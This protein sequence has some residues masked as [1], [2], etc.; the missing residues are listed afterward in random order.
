ME[1]VSAISAQM[2][3]G[4]M[5][6]GVGGSQSVQYLHKQ[7]GQGGGGV[8]GARWGGEPISATSAQT[9]GAGGGEG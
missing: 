3:W 5:G 6:G 4:L 7:W 9:M 8:N 1:P 2:G